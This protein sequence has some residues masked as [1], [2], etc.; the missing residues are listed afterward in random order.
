MIS[1]TIL[2]SKKIVIKIGSNTLSDGEGMLN[3]DFF[4]NFTSQ[5][6]RLTDMGKQIIIVSSGARIA[7]VSTLG[8]WKRKEDL[9]YKQALCAIGQVELM[10]SFRRSFKEE[11]L[12]IG[13]ILVTRDDLSDPGRTVYIRNTLFTLIDEGVIPIINENDSVSVDEIKIGDNDNLAALIANL[14]N[15]DLL[16]LLSDIDGV[17]DKNPKEHDDAV[18]QETITDIAKLRR[19][20]SFGSSGSFGT[21]GIRTK[22]EAAEKVT[23]YGIPMILAC[24]K[25]ENIISSL[26]D[27]KEKASLFLPG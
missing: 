5:V 2:D 16:I 14:W 12:L 10:D 19:E 6:K 9:H 4:M 26:I 8:K 20:I 7:G 21:G 25:H 22:I 27:K 15:A 18:I 24:G 23:Q 11:D 3:R 17:Y 1:E 13:Q